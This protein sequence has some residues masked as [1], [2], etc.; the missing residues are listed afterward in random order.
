MPGQYFSGWQAH[1]LQRH[2]RSNHLCSTI[3]AR[4]A[5]MD[6][7]IWGLA[8]RE[9]MK[10]SACVHCVI[11]D[12][13]TQRNVC[14]LNFKNVG[15]ENHSKFE[16]QCHNI[17]LQCHA[18]EHCQLWKWI[19]C[20]EVCWNED[21][22]VWFQQETFCSFVKYLD[23]DLHPNQC[24]WHGQCIYAECEWPSCCL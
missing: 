9:E 2:N 12:T 16:L 6:R 8:V 21:C 5:G 4:A 1:R 24:L 14:H 13:S 10:C 7:R 22:M 11:C 18:M 23:H 20:W 19:T 17:E 3:F 15:V